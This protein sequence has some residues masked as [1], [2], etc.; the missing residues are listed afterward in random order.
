MKQG[1][2]GRILPILKLVA[3]G[4]FALVVGFFQLAFSI[5]DLGRGETIA[6]RLITAGA[7]SVLSGL[8]IG[9]FNPRAWLLAGL[10]A[11]ATGPLGIAVLVSSLVSGLSISGLSTRTFSWTSVLW[12]MHPW[13]ELLS[14][15]FA[16]RLREGQIVRRLARRFGGLRE[17]R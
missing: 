12:L 8:V 5:S 3:F 6:S 16:A 9:Y 14:S 11:W 1:R 10:A 17:S 4:V 15:Y 7:L 2:T 13:V